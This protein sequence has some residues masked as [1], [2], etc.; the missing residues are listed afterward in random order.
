[1]A[2]SDLSVDADDSLGEDL[3][4]LGVVEGVLQTV[5]E[6]QA[7]WE[8]L[9]ELVWSWVRADGENSSEFVE[10]PVLWSGETLK[11]LLRSSHFVVCTSSCKKAN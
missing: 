8:G 5:A 6:E 11:M 1:M 2:G 9:A 4:G 10:H 7:Q 3:L